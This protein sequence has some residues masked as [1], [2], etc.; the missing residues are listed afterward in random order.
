MTLPTT[1]EL[2]AKFDE[3][4][5]TDIEYERVWFWYGIAA[6]T[7]LVSELS[8]KEYE[9]KYEQFKQENGL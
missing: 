6:Y 4:S 7:K 2:N 5:H 3:L 8:A 9:K 1:E